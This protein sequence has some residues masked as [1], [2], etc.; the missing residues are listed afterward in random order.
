MASVVSETAASTDNGVCQA[1]ER[2]FWDLIHIFLN[3]LRIDGTD[4]SRN[5]GKNRELHVGDVEHEELKPNDG[6]IANEELITCAVGWG[7]LPIYKYQCT[8]TGW[9]LYPC[10]ACS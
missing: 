4:Q 2:A 1:R 7:P 3:R 5:N 10:L 6:D 9:H 8:F